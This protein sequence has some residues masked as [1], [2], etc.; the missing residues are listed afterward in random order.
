MTAHEKRLYKLLIVQTIIFSILLCILFKAQE[1]T[2]EAL[3]IYG[4]SIIELYKTIVEA[5]QTSI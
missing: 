3:D 1:D 2:W 4:R 5:S